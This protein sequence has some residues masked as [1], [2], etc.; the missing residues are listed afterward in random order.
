MER[1]RETHNLFGSSN[2]LPSDLTTI[3]P[4]AYRPK[5]HAVQPTT[6]IPAFRTDRVLCGSWVQLS[7]EHQEAIRSAIN[8]EPRYTGHLNNGASCGR[9]RKHDGWH[10]AGVRPVAHEYGGGEVGIRWRPIPGMSTTAEVVHL[11]PFGPPKS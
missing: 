5:G 7:L 11:R 4:D 9:H 1:V 10:E 3:P 8:G 2:A 6:P